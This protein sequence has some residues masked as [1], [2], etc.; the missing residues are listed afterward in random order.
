MIARIAPDRTYIR[1]R[2]FGSVRL[3]WMTT[4]DPAPS[5]IDRLSMAAGPFS[6]RDEGRGEATIP[7]GRTV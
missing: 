4:S 3:G 6:A 7:M 5:S 1:S 2:L